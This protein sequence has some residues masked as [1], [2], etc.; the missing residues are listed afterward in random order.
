M[1]NCLFSS[2]IGVTFSGRYPL[3]PIPHNM[4]TL[5]YSLV[6]LL[7]LLVVSL[8]A[9]RVSPSQ[10]DWFER[11]SK[12]DNAPGVESMILNQDPEPPL[13]G[14]FSSLYNGRDLHGWKSLGGNCKFEAVGESI[15]ATCVPGSTSTYLVTEK[16]DYRDFLFTC[17]VKWEV[18]GNTGIQFRSK[19]RKGNDRDIVYGPQIELEDQ[20]R[21]RGWSGAIYGQSCGGYWYPLWLDAHQDVRN[22]IDYSDWNRITV[23]A[24]GRTVKSWVNGMPAGHFVFP[25]DTY[26]EGFFGIQSHSGRQGTIRFRNLRVREL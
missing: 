15:I 11:Y 19:V 22:A 7:S 12:Q 20:P 14:N 25:D 24:R 18:E 10:Q 26:L 3:N 9:N 13:T 23:E 16:D 4:K 6:P 1:D 21:Q 5:C 8:H 2:T 17:E